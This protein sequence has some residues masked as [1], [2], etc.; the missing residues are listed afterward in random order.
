MIT[1]ETNGL[2]KKRTLILLSIFLKLKKG[3]RRRDE[4]RKRQTADPAFLP[5]EI[6]MHYITENNFP[7]SLCLSRLYIFTIFILSLLPDPSPCSSSLRL[8]SLH[9]WNILSRVI[10]AILGVGMETK[11]D[12]RRG[13]SGRNKKK[14]K[15]S[16]DKILWVIIRTNIILILEVSWGHIVSLLK[17]KV[18]E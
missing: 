6:T 7:F 1:M 8:P 10:G 14:T 18:R 16:K 3:R 15:W 5:K 4:K 17:Y 9:H 11:K 2:I 13:K 12:R